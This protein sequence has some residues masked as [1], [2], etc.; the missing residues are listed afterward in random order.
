M[1][2]R[3][4]VPK[5]L[6]IILKMY[7]EARRFMAENGNPNQ[8]INGYPG[9]EVVQ[10]DLEKGQLYVCQEDDE[11]CAVF[12]FFTEEEPNYRVIQDGAW[13]NDKPY[14]TVHRITSQNKRKGAASFCIDWC[15]AKCPNLRMDTHRDNLPMQ[16]FLKKK[17]FKPCG[18]IQVEDGSER[19]AFQKE[20]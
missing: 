1:E 10:R 14:G 13:L 9:E 20:A 19:I 17:G 6:D 18:V 5:G 3:K 8:W 11:I 7:E 4:A 16:S 12:V 2:I 15:F